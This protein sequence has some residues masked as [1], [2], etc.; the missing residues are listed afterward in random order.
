MMSLL[1]RLHVVAAAARARKPSCA[2][3]C[4]SISRRRR[5]E[6]RARRTA[7][8]RSAMGGTARPRQRSAACART[9][10]RSGRGGRST[11]SP[12]MCGI[13]LR[14]MFDASRGEHLR[15]AVAGAR[16]RRQH[17]DLQLHGGGAAANAAGADPDSLVV[18]TWRAKPFTFSQGRRVRAAFDFDGSTYR[19]SDGSVEA[20]IF[21]Y[22]GFERLREASAPFLR[23]IFTVFR[24][25]RMNVLIDGQAE[26]TDAQYVSGR[27]LSAAS[28]FHRAPAGCSS[29]TTI[30]RAPS[31][32]RWSVPDMRND[33]SARSRTPS[34]HR[35]ASTTRRS[36]SSASRPT[37]SR[38][39]SRAPRRICTCRCRRI[40]RRGD[41]PSFTDPNYYWAEIMGR[42]R[43]GVTREQAQRG[44]QRGVCAMGG[45]HGDE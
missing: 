11:S 25:G 15:G 7:R 21:P 27:L 32:W 23:S 16:H 39:S 35:F 45:A 36:P 34:A 1:R 19:T 10:A 31:R 12:R 18:M 2:K 37:V 30:G 6:R 14:T 38:A 13:A 9:S 43:P 8:G 29:R 22:P 28:R 17:R 41:G 3:S 4:S 26:L 5:E 33:D 40:T 42:L 44:A 24:G 20:R